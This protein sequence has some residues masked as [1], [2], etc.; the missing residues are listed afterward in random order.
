MEMNDVA[1]ILADNLLDVANGKHARAI[2]TMNEVCTVII[3]IFQ[4]ATDEIDERR[5]TELGKF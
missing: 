5:S 3:I 2:M 4:A 1:E